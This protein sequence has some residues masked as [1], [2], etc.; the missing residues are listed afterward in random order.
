MAADSRVAAAI[1]DYS[2]I[3]ATRPRIL[4]EVVILTISLPD[5]EKR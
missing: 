3:R 2:G 1:M 4:V 5:N